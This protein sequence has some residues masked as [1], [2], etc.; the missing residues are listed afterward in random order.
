MEYVSVDEL[1]KADGLRI[2][3]V[4][5]VPSPWSEAAKGILQVKGIP[6]TAARFTPEAAA[7]E[8]WTGHTSAPI[9][10]HEDEAPRTG[11]AEILLLA[12]RLAPTPSLLPKDAAD[13]ALCFGIAHE[14]CGEDGL[15]WARRL[16]G[17]H[18]G[19]SGRGGFP[20][21]VAQ[22][23]GPKYGYRPETGE[24]ATERVCS[25]LGML[26]A[27]LRAQREAGN[28]YLVGAELTAVDIYLATFMALFAPLPPEQCPMPDAFRAAFE[29]VDDT[30]RAA[31]DGVLLEHRDRIYREHL[32]LPIVL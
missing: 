27:R 6:F 7:V 29:T 16:A 23:L 13:R 18:D 12:E 26:A 31:L 4:G 25:L 11:W 9:A 10:L 2:V 28:D 17:I 19:M 30:T 21:P 22:Y 20:K 8:A 1:K 5:G 24:R 32:E 15:G 14:I 3:F